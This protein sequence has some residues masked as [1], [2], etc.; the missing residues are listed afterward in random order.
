[1]SVWILPR[2]T[3]EW[4][5]PIVVTADGTP[6]TGWTY[7]LFPP[8]YRPDLPEEVAATPDLLDDGVGILVGPGTG[9]DL[10]RGTYR[11][12]VRY[13]AAPEAPVLD[14]VGTIH[15]T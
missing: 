3:V 13:V 12:W 6:V 2:I 15:I 5:G 10:A 9:N 8:A 14:D 7:A 11:I 1:M 4:V